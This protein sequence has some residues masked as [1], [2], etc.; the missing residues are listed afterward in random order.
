MTRQKTSKRS[1]I[2]TTEKKD[3]I[4]SQRKESS[5]SQSAQQRPKQSSRSDLVK[6]L[7]QGDAEFL[8]Q[9]A[10]DGKL[11]IRVGQVWTIPQR[12]GSTILK[13]DYDDCKKIDRR[14]IKNRLLKCGVV[15]DSILVRDSPSGNG[16]HVVVWIRGRF[17]KMD[18]I[19][20]EAI[21]EQDPDRSAQNFRRAH[22]AD[23]A[24]AHNTNVL[25][26]KKGK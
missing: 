19:A 15:T 23:K 8:L 1:L 9:R 13:C 21:L 25:F 26:E 17:S 24:W 14:T 4:S 7:D 11:R 6:M 3:M 22:Q 12:K 10:K 5:K 2:G 18:C 20:L 16:L